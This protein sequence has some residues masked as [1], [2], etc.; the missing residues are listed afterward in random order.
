MWAPRLGLRAY[1]NDA[2]SSHVVCKPGREHS[3]RRA[4]QHDALR[5]RAIRARPRSFEEDTTV[6]STMT[7][8]LDTM[9]GTFGGG[10]RNGSDLGRK[11]RRIFIGGTALLAAL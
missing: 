9:R 11:V 8:R 4:T 7:D 2:V 6:T 5:R 3:R 1:G 10:S